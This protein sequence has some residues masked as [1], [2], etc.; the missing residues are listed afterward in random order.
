MMMKIALGTSFFA[1]LG[2]LS[3]HAQPTMVKQFSAWGVYSYDDNGKK[4]CYL[5]T[6]PSS[7]EPSNVDH[8]NNYFIVA[9]ASGSKAHYEPQARMGYPLKSGPTVI[10]RIGDETFHM[11]TKDN[12][13]WM[14]NEARV[15]EMIEAMRSGQDMQVEATS[16]RGTATKYSYSLNGVTA[17]LKR[18]NGCN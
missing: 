17:A 5:L 2:A 15:G 7:K 16:Q 1:L 9:P 8:G 3:A 14:R 6:V 10:V 18:L 11:F 12:S 13:A 4:S